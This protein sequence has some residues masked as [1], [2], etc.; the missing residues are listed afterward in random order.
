MGR[1]EQLQAR[2]TTSLRSTKG[3]N[4]V[5]EDASVQEGTSPEVQGRDREVA[6]RSQVN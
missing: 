6:D 3:R 2:P 1:R 5:M 4:G